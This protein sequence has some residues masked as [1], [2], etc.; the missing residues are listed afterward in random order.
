MSW[1]SNLRWKNILS[2]FIYQICDS[3]LHQV[4][5]VFSERK[6]QHLVSWAR[7][8]FGFRIKHNEVLHSAN[9]S[10][11]LEFQYPSFDLDCLGSRNPS[12]PA[13]M[14]SSKIFANYLTDILFRNFPKMVTHDRV[15]S[16]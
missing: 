10:K 7:G 14:A 1:I 5:S 15:T 3:F 16:K 11:L 8:T 12:I 4:D 6:L 2:Q 9:N 13:H